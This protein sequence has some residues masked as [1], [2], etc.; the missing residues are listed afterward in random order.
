MWMTKEISETMKERKKMKNNTDK[1]QIFNKRV[2][3][4]C[5]QSKIDFFER[6]CQKIGKLNV[7]SPKQCHLKYQRSYCKAMGREEMMEI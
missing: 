2:S 1:Y 5:L 6:N 7:I 4:M 3:K